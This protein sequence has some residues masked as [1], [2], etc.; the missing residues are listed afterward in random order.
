MLD[1]VGTT[2]LLDNSVLVVKAASIVDA[3]D[4]SCT[5][6]DET[7]VEDEIPLL[8]VVLAT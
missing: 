7:A 2:V 6:V 5:V 1:V 3:V 4:D 8:L